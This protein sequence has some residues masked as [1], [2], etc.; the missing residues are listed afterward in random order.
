VQFLTCDDNGQYIIVVL[1]IM[2]LTIAAH[3]LSAWSV[4]LSDTA[5]YLLRP[6]DGFKCHLAGPHVGSSWILCHMRVPNP[7]GKGIWWSGLQLKHSIAY[8]FRKRWLT[9]VF[10]ILSLAHSEDSL[11]K[12]DY[13]IS[14]NTVNPFLH[15]LVKYNINRNVSKN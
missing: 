7:W 4:C 10:K 3:F 5:V 12:N 11:Q 8:E 9:S 2:R 13:C 15:Y 1:V 14:H 6:L